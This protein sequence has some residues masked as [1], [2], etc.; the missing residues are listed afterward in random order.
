VINQIKDVY[1]KTYYD[2]KKMFLIGWGIFIFT[3]CLSAFICSLLHININ[4]ILNG[5]NSKLP[6]YHSQFAALTGIFINNIKVCAKILVISF[7]PILFLPW[8]SI[9]FNSA[10]LGLMAYAV[11]SVQQNVFNMFIFGVLPHGILEYSAFILSACIATKLQRLWINKLKKFFKRRTS[12]KTLDSML[13][14]LKD[15]TKQF[16]LIILPS[17]AIASLIETYVSKFLLDQFM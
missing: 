1:K 14:N 6:S 2:N 8:L 5:A 16:I 7:I 10:L 13:I 17:I 11:V 3:V 12:K 15:I 4:N 9:I